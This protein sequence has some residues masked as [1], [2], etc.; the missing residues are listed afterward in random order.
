MKNYN[1]TDTKTCTGRTSDQQQYLYERIQLI[2]LKEGYPTSFIDQ[3]FAILGYACDEGVKRNQGRVGAATGADIIKR[4]LAKMP[5]HLD[6]ETTILDIGSITCVD[7]NMEGAQ[8]ILA[9]MV[10]QLLESNTF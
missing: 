2:N 5:N 9:E 3:T 1:P 4:Q 7:S 10:T 8:T 6:H